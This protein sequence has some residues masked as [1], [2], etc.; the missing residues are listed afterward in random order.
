MKTLIHF[1]FLSDV[2]AVSIKSIKRQIL[3]FIEEAEHSDFEELCN[4]F[5]VKE[6]RGP[7]NSYRLRIEDYRLGCRYDKQKNTLILV[8]F[9]HRDSIYKYFP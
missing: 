8:R 4:S 6:L 3:D 5:D 7:A 9:M 2:D 1:R